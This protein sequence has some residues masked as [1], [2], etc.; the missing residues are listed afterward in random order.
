MKI[1]NQTV[2]NAPR[3][4]MPAWAGMRRAFAFLVFYTSALVAS[5]W[6]AYGVRFDF[7]VPMEEKASIYGMLMG[8]VPLQLFW[9]YAF[10]QFH[11]L[12][13]YFGIPG[14]VRMFWAL[15]ISGCILMFMNLAY[16]L[17]SAPPRGVILIDFLLSLAMLAS[18]CLVWRVFRQ[19]GLLRMLG[20]DASQRVRHRVA[21]VGAG[22]AGVSL[23]HELHLKKELGL[24]VVAFFDDASEKWNAKVMGIPV[25]GPPEL[26]NNG[27]A[28]SYQIEELILSIPSA[29]AARIREVVEVARRSGVKY[30][31][32]PSLGELAQGKYQLSQL[33]AVQIEDLLG[34]DPVELQADEIQRL[35]EGRRVMVTGAGGSIGSELCRQIAAQK[36]ALLLLVERSE[37]QMYPI[38]QELIRLGH[39]AV[40]KPLVADILH[41]E[42]IEQ[43]FAKFEPEL[44]F[45]AAA[46]K[47]VP[48]MEAQ[49]SEAIRN[50]TLGT[51][52]LAEIALKHGVDRFIMISTD[53]AINPTNVMGATKRLAEMFIQAFDADNPGKTRFMAVRFGNV[54][55]S[56]GSVVPMFKEQIAAGGPVTVTHPDMTRYFMTIPEA[57]G[58]VLQSSVLGAGGEIFVLDMGQPVRILDMAIQMIKLS[59]LEPDKDI[60]I[61]FMGIRPGEKLFEELSY[62]D[63]TL[64]RTEH[65][66]IMR[67]R[68]N[69]SEIGALREIIDGLTRQLFVAD[70]SDLKRALQRAVPEYVPQLSQNGGAPQG[71]CSADISGSRS[72]DSP[73]CEY[74]VNSSICLAVNTSQTKKSAPQIAALAGQ[75]PANKNV[76][77]TGKK[78]AFV[79]PFLGP[80]STSQL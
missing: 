54:L 6:L 26:L 14:L 34:R 69:P 12:P 64:T 18:M 22:S 13:S 45:H 38:E 57:V 4:R 52:R 74:R 37:V 42:R 53:K 44:V 73:T 17:D 75:V 76:C 9:L 39:R 70:E 40:I 24:K 43:I 16:G 46:H 31:T 47:H 79:P 58:L 61:Q 56:S 27:V 77:A 2:E 33:R 19:Q 65:P 3:W 7:G 21:I 36:P 28:K 48:L 50:N 67:L 71:D 15:F 8:V 49:P 32:V 60:K 11:L 35:V 63:E 30:K 20:L 80:K 55:G 1:T 25:L 5:L 10:H 78:K 41:K 29:S 68:G 51:A 72:E 62:S 66:K 59:G 23:A